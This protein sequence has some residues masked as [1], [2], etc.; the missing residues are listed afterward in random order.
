MSALCPHN[1]SRGICLFLLC[2]HSADIV[3][4]LCGHISP[5]IY[6]RTISFFGFQLRYNKSGQKRWLKNQPLT[7]WAGSGRAAGR[8]APAA[9]SCSTPRPRIAS[10]WEPAGCWAYSRSPP[11]QPWQWKL[12]TFTRILIQ[13]SLNCINFNI[14]T[15]K[16]KRMNKC[17]I[18][19]SKPVYITLKLCSSLVMLPATSSTDSANSAIDERWRQ[20]PWI[21]LVMIVK[22][23]M[24]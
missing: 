5:G 24:N 11:A 20:T 16:N 22:M 8:G 13:I 15:F 1:I 14:E 19:L 21:S 3:R 18:L 23:I 6:V 2:G 10:R 4:T 12:V 17:L 7:W 9:G